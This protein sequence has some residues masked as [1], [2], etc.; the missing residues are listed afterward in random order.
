MEIRAR[1]AGRRRICRRPALGSRQRGIPSGIAS[2]QGTA[3]GSSRAIESRQQWRPSRVLAIHEG[4]RLAIAD[5]AIESQARIDRPWPDRGNANGRQAKQSELV[6]RYVACSGSLWWETRNQPAI[7]SS[8]SVSP[9]G[10][11]STVHHLKIDTLTPRSG[12]E[13]RYFAPPRGVGERPTTPP[14]GAIRANLPPS[15]TPPRGDLLRSTI[16]TL[17]IL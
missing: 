17:E 14:R 4:S 10:Q 13:R 7:V 12:V 8:R 16:Y 15:P 6:C 9:D 1:Q 2:R 3:D 5:D 11:T